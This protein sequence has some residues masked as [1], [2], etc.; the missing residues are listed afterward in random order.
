MNKVA[1][2]Q[3]RKKRVRAKVS[4]TKD[5]PR[6]SVFRSNKEIYAQLVNDKKDET[7]VSFSSKELTKKERKGKTK[8]EIAGLVGEK[9][10]KLAKKK[11]IKT[12]V[13]DRGG[14]KYHGRVAAL[15][16]GVRKGGINF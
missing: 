2:R 10:A 7:L 14:Y 8:S 12:A 11:K 15:A 4:G 13:F 6:L 16:E 1:R 3:K 9:L 5:R